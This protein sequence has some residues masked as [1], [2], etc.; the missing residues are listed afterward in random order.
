MKLLFIYNPNA[1]RGVIVQQLDA[2]LNIFGEKGYAVSIRRTREPHDGQRF[3]AEEGAQYDLVVCAG[4][5]GTLSEVVAGIMAIP[6]KDRPKVGI[7]PAG[8]TNDTS[9]N[10][11]IPNGNI[12]KAARLAVEGEPFPTDIGG[13]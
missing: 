13:F 8:S 4:G 2:I 7:I 3:A 9:A 10:Y 12:V 11:N 1:G 6:K 5:D